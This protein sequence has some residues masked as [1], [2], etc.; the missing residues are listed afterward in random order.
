MDSLKR[1]ARAVGGL[2]ILGTI[3]GILSLVFSGSIRSAS[4]QLIAVHSNES[5]LVLGA[6]FVL[7]MGM[8][9]AF[10]PILMFPILK[11]VSEPLAVGF[12]VFRGGLEAI[13]YI[14]TTVCWLLLVPLSREYLQAGNLNDAHYLALGRIL[15]D[16]DAQAS[17]LTI[18]FCIGATMFYALLYKSKLVPRWLSSWGL[19][20]L[21][22][23]VISALLAL[24]SILTTLSTSYVAL[25]LPLALQEM[26]L[27]LWLIFKGFNP[28][29]EFPHL[30]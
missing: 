30:P 4:N 13:L 8:A 7:L 19:L 27:A 1:T 28:P 5:S 25:Q 17:I 23:Y 3:S 20:A 26:V 12:V 14:S 18:V 2:Y 21:I 10:I 11:K 16:G 9:L 15:F 22:P 29:R 6:L 24:F